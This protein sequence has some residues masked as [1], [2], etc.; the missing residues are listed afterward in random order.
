MTD[1]ET[2]KQLSDE[3]LE[4]RYLRWRMELCEETFK[5]PPTWASRH[6]FLVGL[7]WTI[8]GY[9][10]YRAAVWFFWHVH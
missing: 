1:W 2:G 9:G 7:L 3:E 10:V 4:A 5:K 8:A 6:P